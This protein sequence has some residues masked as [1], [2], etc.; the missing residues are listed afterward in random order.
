MIDEGKDRHRGM[1]VVASLTLISMWAA[2]IVFAATAWYP[3]NPITTVNVR[4]TGQPQV[5]R[6]MY[7]VVDYCKARDWAPQEVRFSLVNEVT[8][9]LP[10]S[11]LSLPTGCHTTSIRV[12][13]PKHIVPTAYRFQLETIYQ[14]WPWRTIQY[15]RQS[16]VFQMRPDPDGASQ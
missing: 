13:L 9:V 4:V 8:V 3:W 16:P 14:P 6:P 15:V 12:P 10:P 2:M 11:T 5:G 1:M 7:I